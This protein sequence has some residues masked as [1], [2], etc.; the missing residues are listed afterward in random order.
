MLK[1]SLRGLRWAAIATLSLFALSSANAT[2]INIVITG[3][4]GAVTTGPGL[5][6]TPFDNGPV[7]TFATTITSL[8]PTAFNSGETQLPTVGGYYTIGNLTVALSSLEQLIFTDPTVWN[9][10]DFGFGIHDVYFAGDF[11][12][13]EFNG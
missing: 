10:Q 2:P 6:T 8:T 5:A 4:W 1:P 12:D 3:S 11:M 13:L 9:G 7:F